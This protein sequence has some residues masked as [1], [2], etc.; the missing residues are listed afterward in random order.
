M[1]NFD[2]GAATDG[3]GQGNNGSLVVGARCEK[4]R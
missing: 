1:W 2:G 4:A 3:T